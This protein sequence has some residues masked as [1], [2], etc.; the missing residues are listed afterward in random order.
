MNRRNIALLR[1]HALLSFLQAILPGGKIVG[2][3]YQFLNP[4]RPDA[5]LGNM[6]FNL[7]TQVWKD[8]AMHD[9]GGRG[10]IGLYAYVMR[11]RYKEAAQAVG[12]GHYPAATYVSAHSEPTAE[13]LLK[14][15]NIELSITQIWG[16]TWQAQD[17]LVA[18]YLMSR[19]YNGYI[20]L[21]LR[22]HPHLLHI[23][24]STDQIIRS[25]HPAMVGCVRVWPDTKIQA[26][27]RTYLKKDGSGKAEINQNK[28]LLGYAK[29]GAITLSPLNGST[30]VL[31]EGIETALSVYLA[32]DLPTWSTISASFLPDVVLPSVAQVPH[33]IIAADHDD[34]G[35]SAANRLRERLLYEDRTVEVRM[36][37][38]KGTDFNDVLQGV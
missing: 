9:V 34:A 7:D 11:M 33:I 17:T 28:K 1:G 10:I 30:L 4:N 29:G 16:Q 18:L 13:E 14:A 32:W 26:I 5:N 21:V 20:P 37:P 8:F 35:I 19:S 31:A 25:H 38:Q 27:H 3:E 2:R 15:K 23:D 12:F 36:P 6:S 22:Y 24:D